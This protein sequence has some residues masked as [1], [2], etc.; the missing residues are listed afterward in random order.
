M[1]VSALS[2][3]CLLALG[4]RGA[5]TGVFGGGLAENPVGPVGLPLALASAP[6]KVAVTVGDHA[7]AFALPDLH[8][9]LTALGEAPVRPTVLVFWAFWC[10]TWKDA[11][12]QMRKLAAE[13]EDLGFDVLAVSVDGKRVDQFERLTG[14]EAPFP[15]LLDVGGPVSAR[16]GIEHVPTVFVVDGD[17]TVRMRKSGYPGNA[18]L[19][20]AL[21]S[22]G[23]RDLRT[24][25]GSGSR[26]SR[27]STPARRRPR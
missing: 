25:P 20:S 23:G 21:R 27:Q 12:P 2:L 13:R 4:G 11:L 17:G 1:W 7:P 19:L 15:I 6:S 8:G 9:R 22:L 24:S 3:S 5:A 26:H 14:G 10:D 18:V 16:Y